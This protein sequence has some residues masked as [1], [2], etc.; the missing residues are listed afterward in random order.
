[1]KEADRYATGTAVR[2][3]VLGDA[4]VDGALASADALF[5]PL[6]RMIT[7]F[8]WGTVW[9]SDTIDRRTRS[10]INIAMLS[11]LNRPHEIALHLRGALRNGCTG[12]EIADIILQIAAYCGIPAVIETMKLAREAFADDEGMDGRHGS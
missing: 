4:Y 11:A 12:E 7:E 10:L 8:C 9:T 6:Q 1:V 5:D 2:R 3:A